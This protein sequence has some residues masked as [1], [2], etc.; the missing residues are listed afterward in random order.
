MRRL[1]DGVRLYR[2][3]AHFH[4]KTSNTL[5][6]TSCLHF[7]V[8]CPFSACWFLTLSDTCRL[9]LPPYWAIGSEGGLNTL[10]GPTQVTNDI[11]YMKVLSST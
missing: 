11:C 3:S 9:S 6:R 10:S 5:L 7:L 4:P 2:V 1:H 8:S